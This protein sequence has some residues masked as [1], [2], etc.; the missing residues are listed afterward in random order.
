L[1]TFDVPN[2]E[3]SCIRRARSNTPLQ[4]LMSLNETTSLE[5]AAALAKRMQAAAESPEKRVEAGFKL[6]TARP[7]SAK[8]SAALLSLLKRQ[9]ERAAKDQ[10]AADAWTVVARVLLNLDETITKE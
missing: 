7:P 2:G 3:A 4:A 10:E 6:C 5:A 9:Q 8:E 1:S